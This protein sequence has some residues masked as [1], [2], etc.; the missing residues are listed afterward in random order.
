[1]Y[2]RLKA[3]TLGV[4]SGFRFG[5]DFLVYRGKPGKVHADSSVL[6]VGSADIN[7][8]ATKSTVVIKANTKVVN[9]TGGSRRI[10]WRDIVAKSR[11]QTTVGKSLVVFDAG[12]DISGSPGEVNIK[13]WMHK[14]M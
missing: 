10:K 5:C 7:A 12:D 14:K 6:C 8:K 4:R 1:M 2:K 3:K 9:A 11:L 13:R